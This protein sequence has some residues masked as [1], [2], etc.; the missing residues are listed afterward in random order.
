[1][2]GHGNDYLRKHSLLV[3]LARW[4][5]PKVIQG[6][7]SVKEQDFNIV[8]QKLVDMNDGNATRG[9]KRKSFKYIANWIEKNL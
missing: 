3:P 9:I 8:V 4:R 2:A 7:A 6:E 5:V 1:V